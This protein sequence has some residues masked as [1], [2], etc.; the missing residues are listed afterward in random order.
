MRME[1]RRWLVG[2]MVMVLASLMSWPG[3]A[4]AES[5]ALHVNDVSGLDEP[6]PL[7]GGMPFPKG[8]L[9]DAQ[10]IR[11][12]RDGEEVP[13]QIDV[14][15]TWRD[16]SIRWAL[17]GFTAS[18]QGDYTVEYGPEVNRSAPADPLTVQQHDDGALTVNTGAAVYEF[19]SDQLLPN[20][21]T[22]GDTVVLESAG[23]GAYLVDNQGRTARVSGT[24][25]QITSQLRKQGPARLVVHRKGWYVTPAGDRVARA[26]MWFYFAANTPYMRMTHTLV[27]TENTN[28]W[29]IRDYGL[30]LDT[31]EPANEVAFALSNPAPSEELPIEDSREMFK[32][33]KYEDLGLMY[34]GMRGR[35]WRTY[36]TKPGEDEVY[37]LQETYPHHFEREFRAVIGRVAPQRAA[38]LT[39]SGAEDDNLWMHDWETHAQVAGDWADGRYDD[40]GM[41]VVMPW[42]A[43]RFP[44][45]IAFGPK[46][47]R[48]ALWSGRSGRDLDWRPLTLVNEYWKKWA[49]AQRSREHGAG[50]SD[51]RAA[52]LAQMNV[53][54]AGA[55]R[56]HDLWL[57]P[58]TSDVDA[59]TIERRATAAARPPLMMAE[60]EWLTSTE[61][62]G[63]PVHPKDTEWFPKVEQVISEY[64]DGLLAHTNHLRPTG[65]I[66][67]GR[68]PYIRNANQH[69]R[70]GKMEDYYLRRN[71][72]MLYARSGERKYYEYANRFNRFSG[73]YAVGH[74]TGGD[75]KVKGAFVQYYADPPIHWG[76]GTRLWARYIAGNDLKHWLIGHYLTGDEYSWHITEMVSKVFKEQWNEDA[77]ENHVKELSP[78]TTL[79]RL[80]DLY[81]IDW[82][83]QFLHMAK[84]WA[85]ALIDLDNPTGRSEVTQN[86]VFYKGHRKMYATYMYYR[87]TGDDVAKASLLKG[88]DYRHRFN[89]IAPT[90]QKNWADLLYS[91]AY[92]WTNRPVYLRIVKALID[93]VRQGP[94]RRPT[95]HHS[96]H[97]LGSVPTGLALLADVDESTI[98]PY[99]VLESEAPRP[100]VFQKRAG[101]PIELSIFVRMANAVTED[102]QTVVNIAPPGT[103]TN[104][105]ES[106]DSV[107][108]EVE[109]LFATKYDG[110]RDP[111]D[112]HVTVTLSADAPAGRYTLTIPD[113]ARLVVLES[114]A[115][116]I[117]WHEPTEA[118]AAASQSQ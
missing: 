40:H 71:S 95:I 115:P 105:A 24:E 90:F 45:E 70:I 107:R 30:E 106:L 42:L 3:A 26:K 67:W 60:P 38:M 18:P 109:Q 31:P 65:F 16:G 22:M 104:Q 23:D 5:F 49:T 64:W 94:R 52:E 117:D 69:F 19:E 10:R 97:I 43:Q 34:S 15:A 27:L 12:M 62:L 36:T 82:D 99:P 47:A 20:R 75:G 17:A 89:R 78:N 56:T 101:E 13:G 73:D 116:H 93:D 113:T 11:I 46:G 66:D 112:R 8:A 111:R 51:A 53:N 7:V 32:E 102:A 96:W 103:S 114:D 28:Q 76:Y 2:S 58:R 85:H 92:R 80:T 44:K 87:W 86:G 84:T 59:Q 81:T 74:W 83:E 88:V 57:L 21:A 6:W 33:Q 91:E 50:Y 55:A 1:V 25:A 68:N 110:R 100:I 48:V 118:Q 72:W 29:W 4:S 35:A 98:G 108:V 63:W 61:A 77:V 41:T 9:H 39:G 37:M 14:V 54:A 79:N